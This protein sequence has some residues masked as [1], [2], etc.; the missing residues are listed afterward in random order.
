MEHPLT[1]DSTPFLNNLGGQGAGGSG[2]VK[3]AGGAR[4]GCAGEGGGKCQEF[5][6]LVS[7]VMGCSTTLNV[8]RIVFSPQPRGGRSGRSLDVSAHETAKDP[9][10]DRAIPLI[11]IAC[12]L[13]L[14]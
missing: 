4:T 2:Q 7:R 6:L 13:K 9:L 12:T 11:P 3:G 5:P 14:V 1:L 10:I 8:I